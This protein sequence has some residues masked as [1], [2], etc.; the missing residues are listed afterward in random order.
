MRPCGPPAPVD[1]TVFETPRLRVRRWRAQDAAD[2]L[3]VY[4]DA[5]AMRFVGDGQALTA[6]Q[7]QQ[8]LFVT[9]RNYALR[10]YGMFALEA[11]DPLPPGLVGFAGLVH[12]DGQ[13]EA[14]VKYAL[15]RAHW[16][17]GLATEAVRG[18]LA[19]GARAHGLRHIIATV[20]PGHSASQRV[21]SKAGLQRGALRQNDDGSQTQLFEWRAPPVGPATP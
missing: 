2:L 18:L 14:E 4:G 10:G 12:P 16:G 17:Q 20:A 8:W 19:Y 5:P 6:A 9:E 21:L 7:C 11:R 15:A 3:R 1:D 13:P